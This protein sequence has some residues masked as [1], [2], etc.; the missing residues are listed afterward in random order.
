METWL[1]SGAVPLLAGPF[2]A[3]S[4]LLAAAGVMKV[5]RPRYTAGALRISHLPAN[6]SLVRLLGVAELAVGIGAIVTGS[7]YWAMGV[8]VSY[9]GFAGFV[10]FALRSGAP[11]SSCGCF[12]SPD[13]PPSV[14]HVVLNTMAAVVA[15]AVAI[16][17]V[18]PWVGLSGLDIGT[19]AAFLLFS[20]ATVYLL[21][22]IVNVLPQRSSTQRESTVRLSPTRGAVSE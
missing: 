18:G 9:L 19:G 1:R 13:T 15:V 12:G 14:G 7:P 20:G 22:A 21:Y 3:I 2:L 4:A 17:P 16:R 6:E 5:L 11:I 8:G 10:V